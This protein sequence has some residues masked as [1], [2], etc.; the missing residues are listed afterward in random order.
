MAKLYGLGASV[1]IIGALF[2]INHYMGA[3]TMLIVGLGTESLIFFFSAFEPPHVEPDWSLVYPQLA[4]IYHETDSGVPELQKG[5]SGTQ[6]LDRMLEK[7]KIGPE[8]IES[9]GTGLR[10]LTDTTSKLSDVSNA[11]VANDKFVSTMKTATDSVSVLNESY[12]KTAKSLEQNVTASEEH[13]SSLQSVSKSAA[14]LSHSYVAAAESINHEISL[15]KEFSASLTNATVFTNKFVEKYRESAELLAK[16]S[17]ALNASAQEESNYNKQLQKISNNLSALNALYELHLQG[18]NE[19][20]ASTG[21]VNETLNKL[22][23]KLNESIEKTSE[24]KQE[25]EA[26]SKN[27]AALNKVY[28]NML[29]AMNVGNK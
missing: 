13:L 6:E 1:V 17:E 7:A 5:G 20:M 8:L 2:K 9:L 23:A 27:I 24:F 22:T 26:F 25:V 14:T 21:K 4:G 11:S 12:K 10:K 29:S 3:D 19:Q 16:S 15:N 18:S 28:G